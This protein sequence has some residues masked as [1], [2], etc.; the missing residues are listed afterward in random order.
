MKLAAALLASL[1][2]P[3]QAGAHAADAHPS[4]EITQG[5]IAAYESSRSASAQPLA[6]KVS[7]TARDTA[8]E[9]SDANA[10]NSCGAYVSYQ[11]RYGYG[12]GPTKAV[13]ARQALAMC[14]VSQCQIV[15][16]GC[17]E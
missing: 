3:M 15:S 6:T 10:I 12:I 5:K 2:L 17:E 4:A 8:S 13:A 11:S 1:A 9:P 14:G 16:L 7:M